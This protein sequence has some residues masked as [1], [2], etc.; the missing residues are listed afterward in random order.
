[1]AGHE[2]LVE[3]PGLIL[4]AYCMVGAGRWLRIIIAVCMLISWDRRPWKRKWIQIVFVLLNVAGIYC[5]YGILKEV[6]GR[7]AV[8]AMG[9]LLAGSC[10][11][12]VFYASWVY[13]ETGILFPVHGCSPIYLWKMIMGDEIH[14]EWSTSGGGILHGRRGKDIL[15]MG[16]TPVDFTGAGVI[17]SIKWNEIRNGIGL[18]VSGNGR[19]RWPVRLVLQRLLGTILCNGL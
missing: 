6:S 19:D 9:T 13:G 1:M 14:W 16:Q 15:K 18:P 12:S 2:V 3:I 5:I 10:M 17:W 7:L 4:V 8:V 11:A